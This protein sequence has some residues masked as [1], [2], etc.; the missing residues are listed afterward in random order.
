MDKHPTLIPSRRA[1]AATVAI[2]IAGVALFLGGQVLISVAETT[3][4]SIVGALG[5]VAGA[6]LLTFGL[7]R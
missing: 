7:L 3:E 1:Q 4:G 5:A 2:C 6:A